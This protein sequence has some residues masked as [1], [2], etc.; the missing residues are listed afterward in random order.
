[1]EVLPKMPDAS[2]DLVVTDPPYF[3]LNTV[4]KIQKEAKDWDSFEDMLAYKSFTTKYLNELYRIM[5][6][7]TSCCLFGVKDTCSHLTR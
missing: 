6:D 5:K 4:S 2:V 3:I 7:N 1:M